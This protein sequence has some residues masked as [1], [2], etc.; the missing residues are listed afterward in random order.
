MIVSGY[1]SLDPERISSVRLPTSPEVG[2]AHLKWV[3]VAAQA[4]PSPSIIIKRPRE[5]C[6]LQVDEEVMPLW[7]GH[8]RTTTW[9]RWTAMVAPTVKRAQIRT[10]R[11]PEDRGHPCWPSRGP[12]GAPSSA[13]SPLL[14]EEGPPPPPPQPRFPFVGRPAAGMEWF[15]RG[16]RAAPAGRT[17]TLLAEC[18]R[19]PPKSL[20]IFPRSWAA[21]N[22]HRPTVRKH[23][24]DRSE[25]GQC[26]LRFAEISLSWLRTMLDPKPTPP[27]QSPAGQLTP[28]ICWGVEP[29]PGG[30]SLTPVRPRHQ[31]S[32]R[33]PPEPIPHP[34]HHKKP[35]WFQVRCETEA[36]PCLMPHKTTKPTLISIEVGEHP[37]TRCRTRLLWAQGRDL[38]RNHHRRKAARV[39]RDASVVLRLRRPRRP[40]LA[41]GGRSCCQLGCMFRRH[42]SSWTSVGPVSAMVGRGSAK[43]RRIRPRLT[44]CGPK[45]A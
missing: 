1:A 11:M 16:R 29:L 21:P 3:E 22:Q 41:D 27:N 40:K 38:N 44:R 32:G 25:R 45:S 9:V 13:A 26:R 14:P 43:S 35:W 18:A 33:T 8:R 7:V 15:D 42:R 24:R 31:H 34:P 37:K 17:E 19:I 5:R 10:P 2:R 36:S 28:N 4:E 23:G 6:P 39:A 20:D 30:P 12:D